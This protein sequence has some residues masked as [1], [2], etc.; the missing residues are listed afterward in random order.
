MKTLIS[1][2]ILGAGLILGGCEEIIHRRNQIAEEQSKSD[3]IK[4]QTQKFA[5]EGYNQKNKQ[6]YEDFKNFVKTNG[7]KITSL[8]VNGSQ[9]KSFEYEQDSLKASVDQSFI[10]IYKTKFI[11]DTYSEKYL[12]IDFG[13]DGL[14]RY[15]ITTYYAS[16][17]IDKKG[18]L[19]VAKEYT[20][21]LKDLMHEAKYKGY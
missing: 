9:Y 7:K 17:K 6:V 15:G 13:F 11:I 14:E 20:N 5:L 19:E 12:F 10:R 16:E 3:S 21:T 1:S 4:I 18:V 8:E 2:L